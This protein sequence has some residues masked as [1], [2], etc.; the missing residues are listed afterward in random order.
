MSYTHSIQNKKRPLLLNKTGFANG[1][2]D[3][4]YFEMTVG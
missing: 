2:R 1:H 3:V 4:S